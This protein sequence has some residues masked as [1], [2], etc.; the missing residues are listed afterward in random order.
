MKNFSKKASHTPEGCEQIVLRCLELLDACYGNAKSTR[1]HEASSLVH[2]GI[3]RVLRRLTIFQ[4]IEHIF[5]SHSQNPSRGRIM[6][7]FL[8]RSITHS[9]NKCLVN[10]PKCHK[11]SLISFCPT[12][13]A[14][15][16]CRKKSHPM[17]IDFFAGA[18]GLSAG[19]LREG[20]QIALAIEKSRHAAQT[21]RHNHPGIPVMEIDARKL[22]TDDI[23]KVTGLKAGGI[24]V[25]MGGPPCQGYS[26][27]GL[28][29]PRR[30]QN[31]LYQVVANMACR[32]KVPVLLMEN[33]PGLEKVGGVNF[34]A[35][36][37]DYIQRQGFAV[38]AVE[39]D[40]SKFGVPQ[41]RR[42]LLFLGTHK[43]FT[44]DP[45]L[46][47]PPHSRHSVKVTEALRNLPTLAPGAGSDIMTHKGKPV[48]NH[49]AMAHSP[50]VVAKIQKIQPGSGP[51]SY[52]RLPNTLAHTII[53]GH[54]A[55]PVHPSQ[56][57]T[58]TVREAAR[59]Q[60]IPDGFRFMGPH[61]AQ[62]L[63]VA[64]AVPYNMARALARTTRRIL[65]RL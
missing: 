27:A 58:I 15:H 10:N 44:I 35:Q 65:K 40:A 37:V 20:F 25:I 59:L 47:T 22:T 54:R 21:Y 64:N 41:R 39:L 56:H 42:R 2:P 7:A 3:S 55:L 36:I 53:A 1:K 30:E 49:R 48:Y 50:E 31:L 28:R 45:Q 46:L 18:G 34:K 43:R 61:A 51:L 57:R 24:D 17:A 33:V 12:G 52:R 11:C 62:P 6:D 23:T 38:K 9:A 29:K 32:L 13:L 63:Q 26:V 60:T 19:F 8:S 16:R 5:E 4:Q 14:A